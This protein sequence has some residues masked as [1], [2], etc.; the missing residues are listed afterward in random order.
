MS[1][2]EM[3]IAFLWA[4]MLGFGVYHIDKFFVVQ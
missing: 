4:V 3:W 1:R 2:Q